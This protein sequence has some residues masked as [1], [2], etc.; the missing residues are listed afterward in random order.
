VRVLITSIPQVS[1]IFPIVPI[2]QALQAARHEVLVVA[3]PNVAPAL[4]AADLP[5]ET[6]GRAFDMLAF[7]RGSLPSGMLPVEAWAF[8]RDRMYAVAARPWSHWAR[9]V[10]GP[11][12]ELASRWRPDLIICDPM[13][14]AARATGGVLNVPVVEHRWG[15][16]STSISFH[17]VA[18][19]RVAPVVRK[20]GLAE[21]PTPAFVLDPCPPSIRP[22]HSEPGHPI[23]YI[24]YNGTGTLPEGV[25]AGD[26]PRVCVSFGRVAAS[27]TKG[28]LPRWTLE[29]LDQISGVDVTLALTPKDLEEIGPVPGYVE[30]L[31][32]VPLNLIT[33]RCD[34][35]IHHGGEGTG[36][37]GLCAGVPQVTMPQLPSQVQFGQ[38]LQDYGAARNLADSSSQ[39]SIE[40]IR[41]AI[42]S[43]LE[44]RGYRAAAKRLQAE[45][46][47]MPA[48]AEVVGELEQLIPAAV[49]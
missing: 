25:L 48:P 6:V 47:S 23:R 42:S 26:R 14:I 31:L 15:P 17:A 16:D 33:G 37:T 35:L 2:G 21:L 41:A 20:H 1:H 4:A 10:F 22:P 7:F 45:I 46:E 36:M 12:L 9:E 43:V 34:V 19:K 49:P 44:E 39:R 24:P 40:A 5:V 27:A 32:D 29:A 8:D 38:L 30:V 13:E 18:A 28:A 3:Q 11:Q